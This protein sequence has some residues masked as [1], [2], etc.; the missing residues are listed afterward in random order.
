MKKKAITIAVCGA[1][2]SGMVGAQFYAD[3]R[4]K[5]FYSLANQSKDQHIQKQTMKMDM[6]VWS[7]EATWSY[8][9]LVDPCQPD[10]FVIIKGVDHIQRSWNGY[11][12][13]S[14]IM[15]EI[16][17]AEAAKK[18]QEIFKNKAF[19][20]A[21][22]KVNWFG[23]VDTKF[24]SVQLDQNKDGTHVLWKGIDGFIHLKQQQDR[25]DVKKFELN[26]PEF[27]M[28]SQ[29]KAAN[30]SVKGVE[31]SSGGDGFFGRTLA[32]GKTNF[33]IKQMSFTPENTNKS[34]ELN[35]LNVN[36]VVD[37]N[38]K[39]SSLENTWS[40]DQI[41]VNQQGFKN[42]KFNFKVAG[43]DT[44]AVQTS[45]DTI[46]KI[47]QQ[48]DIQQK[49]VLQKQLMQDFVKVLAAGMSFTSEG[50]QI[51]AADAKLSANIKGQLMAHPYSSLDDVAATAP[52]KATLDAKAEMDK[53]F[54]RNV[55]QASGQF[56][57]KVSD[58]D[59]EMMLQELVQKTH[60]KIN[61]NKV[62]FGF[63]YKDGKPNF[64]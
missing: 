37:V 50:N 27:S 5:E 20:E 45:I 13:H 54:I 4:L 48:C 60:A 41:K 35:N 18:Y 3:H 21:D 25:F 31:L 39:Q 46:N 47:N 24:K 53:A 36:Y 9:V 56:T 55:M 6:G 12:I 42:I 16:S 33:V 32:S 38:A 52:Q 29:E 44:Q 61:G 58:Q 19:I 51:E 10:N 49:D 8:K 1:L 59:Y 28:T 26:M 2:V 22:S 40:I 57:E 62:E 43:L 30:V 15:P 7:G 64:Q 23:S 11:N 63:T 14:E 34:V 17:D